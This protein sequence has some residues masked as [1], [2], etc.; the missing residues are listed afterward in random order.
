MRASRAEPEHVLGLHHRHPRGRG[1]REPDQRPLRLVARARRAAS[2]S[3]STSARAASR[4]RRRTSRASCRGRG[5]RCRR[6]RRSR[7]VRRAGAALLRVAGVEAEL[8]HDH[9]RAARARRAGASTGGRDHAEV[10]GDQRQ[11]RRA[12]RAR[13]R[14]GAR[15]ARG[16]QRP[17]QRVARAARHRP[18]GDEAAEVVDPR[19]VVELERAAEALGP[20]AVAAPLQRRPVVQRVAP[21]LALVGERVRRRAG[22]R[23]VAEQLG[24]RAVVGRARRDVDRHVA[25]QPHAAL[26]G[27]AR[28]ARAHSRSKRTWSAI[29][30]R[31]GE[32]AQSSIQ[33]ALRSRKSIASASRTPARAG[34]RQQPAARPRTPTPPCTASRSGRAARAAASATTTAPRRRASRRTGSASAPE[35]AAG[36]RGGVQLDAAGYGRE[37]HRNGSIVG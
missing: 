21:Q 5:C 12:P 16:C 32:R 30:P 15:P 18:V 31:A 20:P 17:A 24:M 14:T 26:G 13:R 6:R 4:Q 37:V 19:E 2:I 27:V 28:A 10:L 1:E 33:Y 35:P 23:A 34:S 8:Q 25:D 11:A 9:A 22:D 7:V 29:A 3:A 36:K